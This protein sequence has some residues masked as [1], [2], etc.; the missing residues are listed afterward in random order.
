M[1]AQ[2]VVI[3]LPGWVPAALV[4]CSLAILTGASSGV[5]RVL[6]ERWLVGRGRRRRPD[7]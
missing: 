1:E 2:Q 4:A 7:P 6:T 3:T 5:A